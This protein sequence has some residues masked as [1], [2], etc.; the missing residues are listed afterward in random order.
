[1]ELLV[2]KILE[3][4]GGELLNRGSVPITR[5]VQEFLSNVPAYMVKEIFILIAEKSLKRHAQ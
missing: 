4:Q 5:E 1:M 2:D 3:G